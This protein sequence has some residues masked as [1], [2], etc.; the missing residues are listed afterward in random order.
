MRTVRPHLTVLSLLSAT[1]LSA[2]ATLP[3][4][5][6]ARVAKA[7]ASYATAQSLAA[8][9]RDWPA[10]AW[11]AAY[12]DAQLDS[13]MQEALAGSPDLAAAQARVRK[14]EAVASAAHAQELPAVSGN[15]GIE[16]MKQSYNLGIPAQFVPQGYN[17]YGRGTLDFSWELD[18]WGKNRAAVAAAVSD[19]RAAQAD[20]AEARLMLS[21]NVA[22]AYADLARL[23]AERDVADR[24]MTVQGET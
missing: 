5:I 23:Y 18:F 21:T 2:C 1:A 16:E 15:A 17:D 19:A 6:P 14:A 4:A 7:S 9:G 11:W 10:D 13:L 8:P 3:P 12:G 22:A 24:A 20:A